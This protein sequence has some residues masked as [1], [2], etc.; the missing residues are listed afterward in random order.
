MVRME[1]FGEFLVKKGAI[2]R[3]DLTRLLAAQRLVREKIGTIAMREGL[4][5]EDELT[6]FLGEYLGMPLF[7]A[8]V[9]T[10]EK[11]IIHVIPRKMALKANVLPVG[12]GENGELLLAC[13]GPLS[14]TMLQTISRLS[15]RPVRLVLTSP[16][17][18]RKM[19]N[20]F[21]S[22][23]FDTTIKLTG[24]VDLEDT[25][26]II[27]LFE[28]LMLRAI[29]QGAS[30]LHVEPER[31]A[32]AIRFRVDGMLVKTE[33]LPSDLAGRLVS[34]IKVVAGM[35]I[36]ERRKPQDGAFYFLPQSLD[37]AI[38]GVNVRVSTLPVVHGEKAVLRLLP[39]HD[40]VIEL[41]GLGMDAAMLARFKDLLRTPHGIVLVTGPTGSGKSTTLYGALQMLRGETTNITTIEDPVELTVRG[42]NQTQVDTG[43]KLSFADALRSILR[44]DP[45]VIMVGEVRDAE[46]LRIA[47]RAAI[48]GHLVLSTLHTNDA[49]SAFNR[50]ID[51]GAEPFLVA[52]SV[53]AV[54]AQRLVRTICPSCGQVVP[55]S[56]AE[57]RM[58]GLDEAPF[59]IR[60]GPGCDNCHLGFRGRL[61]IFELLEVDEE[62][63]IHI[64]EAANFETLRRAAV[65][66]KGFR[67]LRQDG[68]DKVRRGLTTPEEIM[69]VTI[70]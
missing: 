37:V 56:G 33:V 6:A 70:D 65:A 51:M 30:D 22:R 21:F 66:H 38:D 18:L 16:R 63:K 53:R 14:K 8:T 35:D 2:R 42:V 69:R 15:K 40:E 11:G 54:L 45:D 24:A 12:S 3:V 20:L 52:A 57:L 34:R 5:T 29:N 19:Q 64:M 61:G 41:D 1:R 43:E 32:L 48:T 27:E 4:L 13:S 60:R 25:G 26:F 59:E 31:D 46:T 67:T 23:E 17:K 62:L 7:K 49:P 10:I 68:I 39:P 47:L 58:L 55:I 44:Q 9:D 28:K 50:M 36:A